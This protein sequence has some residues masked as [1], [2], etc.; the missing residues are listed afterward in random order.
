MRRSKVVAT[1]GPASREPD[2][3]ARLI[4]AGVDVFRLNY[5]HGTHES[6]ERMLQA[7]RRASAE[8]GREVGILQDLAGPKI[9][10]GDLPDGERLVL[11]EGTRVELVPERGPIG[12]GRLTC[13]LPELLEELHVGERVLLSDGRVE[14]RVESR[15][16]DAVQMVVVR[17]GS[18]AGRAGINLPDTK[19]SVPSLT[20]KDRLDLRHGLEIGTDMT[21]LSFVR[22]ASDLV[23][24]RRVAA[25]LGRTLFLVA[26]IEKPEAL[27][28]LP[29][30]VREA[31]AIMVARGDLGVEIPAED[32]PL[33]QKRIIR[34]ANERRI[35][36]I[37]ATQMLESMID[38]PVPTRAEAS[39][40]AN[41]IFDGS[42]AVMLSGET[43]AGKYPEETVKTMVRI[44]EKADA[45]DPDRQRRYRSSGV[46]LSPAEAVTRS[47]SRAAEDVRAKAIVVYTE[48]GSTARLLSSQ[49]PAVPIL[50]LS[51]HL[52]TVRQLRLVWGV[53]P[54][55]MPSVTRLAE[56]LALGE[57]ILVD[58][59]QVSPGDAVVVVS[60]TK[61][62]NRGGTNMM[63]VHR[64]GEIE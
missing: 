2:M 44:A 26:K 46:P 31:D 23:E 48:S 41:A 37:T 51:P 33:A 40:V 12:P 11:A 35:P 43:A 63:K 54:R 60:G 50:A 53:Y 62:A 34:A 28:E 15:T 24:T 17:G 22:R 16:G 19:L 6:Q 59:D 57:K 61:A 47:A 36:V 42:D 49:R 14:L 58:A 1:L 3:I 8:V 25:E 64:V 39:D 4:R 7:V 13:T 5:S 30:I 38:N 20:E 27:L 10:T 21:A 52:Q 55:L 56:M 18:L 45:P 29:G 9:R 32:V